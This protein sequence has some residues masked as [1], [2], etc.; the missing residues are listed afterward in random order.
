MNFIPRDYATAVN[1]SYTARTAILV[2]G[3]SRSGT[4]L[5]SRILNILG[6]YLP[7]ELLGPAPSN[8]YGHWEPKRLVLLNEQ[9]LQSFGRSW[10]DPRGMPAGWV[11]SRLGRRAIGQIAETIAED[12]AGA[13]LL[14]INFFA[15]S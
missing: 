9:I 3:M 13:S 2:L 7:D 4:S 15:K 10:D 6:A 11:G 1:R 8:P 5:C 14:L 12:Y